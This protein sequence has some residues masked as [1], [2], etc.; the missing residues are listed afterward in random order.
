LIGSKIYHVALVKFGLTSCGCEAGLG[1][2]LVVIVLLFL[3]PFVGSSA[4]VFEV[5][6][7]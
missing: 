4:G 5:K 1:F 3:V 6:E 7:V 2:L